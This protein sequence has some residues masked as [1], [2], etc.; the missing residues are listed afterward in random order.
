MKKRASNDA[1]EKTL[2][3]TIVCAN[4]HSNPIFPQSG[5]VLQNVLPSVPRTEIIFLHAGGIHSRTYSDILG[6]NLLGNAV[7]EFCS[8]L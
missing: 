5:Q 7:V 1:E 3:N 8:A 6:D 2:T 4:Y